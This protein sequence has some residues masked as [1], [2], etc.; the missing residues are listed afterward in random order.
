MPISE[1]LGELRRRILTVLA[2]VGV[3]V[4]MA[5]PMSGTVLDWLKRPLGLEVYFFSPAEAFWTSLKISFFTGLVLALPVVLYQFWRFMAPGLYRR[6]RRYAL[7]FVFLSLFFF[8]VGE[9]FCALIALPFALKFLVGFGVERGMQPLLSVGMYMDFTIKFYLAFGIIFQMPLALTLL[10]RMGVFEA[11]SLA[12]QRKYAFLVN[13]VV[14]A[15][16]TP[17]ADIFNMM[18]MLIPLTLLFE[19]GLLGAKLFG[20]RG[21]R[22][23]GEVRRDAGAA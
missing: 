2:A 19:L 11:Q 12:R 1:H 7:V 21:V 6:E 10:A 3:G 13:A 23:S 18:L 15:I 16:L 20:A 4:A 9:A 5:L 14:A 8:A 17:T 22:S